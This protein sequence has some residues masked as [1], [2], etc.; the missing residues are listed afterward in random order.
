LK[1]LSATV[2]VVV[3]D[4]VIL[5]T[6]AARCCAQPS[7]APRSRGFRGQDRQEHPM[8]STNGDPSTRRQTQH[9]PHPRLPGLQMVAV[10]G[11]DGTAIIGEDGGVAVAREVGANASDVTSNLGF[12]TRYALMRVLE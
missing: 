10:I 12:R 1:S 7:S 11:D 3:A 4:P 9:Q 5:V 8:A 6:V 2:E